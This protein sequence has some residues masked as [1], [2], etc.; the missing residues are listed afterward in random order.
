ML[1]NLR[2]RLTYANVM[3]TVAVFVA[4]GGSSYAALRITGKN[5]PKDALTGADIKNLTGKDVRN[6]TLTGADVKS[7][8]SADIANGR[9]LAEDFAPG[10]LPKGEQGPQGPQG[11]EGVAATKLFAYI[12]VDDG[13]VA[14][15]A[16]GQGVTQIEQVG[17]PATQGE[18]DVHFNRDLKGCIVQVTPGTGR[19]RGETSGFINVS[20]H[21]LVDPNDTEGVSDNEAR[22]FLSR[23]SDGATVDVP[24][25]IAAFC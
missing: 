10:Q 8:T 21:V 7:L 19:P 16:Y 18:F 15:V 20:T 9:L 25:M 6:N 14:E 24:F 23:T 12:R 4:L 5:V 22:V 11:P 13:N 17:V 3:A 2:S 1:A